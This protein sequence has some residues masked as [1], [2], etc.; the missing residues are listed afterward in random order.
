MVKQVSNEDILEYIK[1]SCKAQGLPFY[2]ED[3]GALVVIA[4]ILKSA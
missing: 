2:V 1:E 4:T 3:E